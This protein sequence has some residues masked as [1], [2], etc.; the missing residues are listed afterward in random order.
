MARRFRTRLVKAT[1]AAARRGGY[2]IIGG[3]PRWPQLLLNP[4]LRPVGVQLVPENQ[5]GRS[6]LDAEATIAKARAEGLSIPQYVAR[7][8]DEHGVVEG[9]I[10]H[11][12]AVIPLPELKRIC[13]IG[14]GTGRFLEPIADIAKS[15]RYEVYETNAGWSEYLK[16]THEVVAHAADGAT[17][18]AT[19]D[20]SQDLVHAH[21]VFAYLPVRVCFAYFLEMCRVCACGGYVVFD[22]Y[23]DEDQDLSAMESWMAHVANY[24]IILPKRAILSLFARE[25][26]DLVDQGY[27]MKAFV[28]KTRYLMFR[29]R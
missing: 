28:G 7:L 19:P 2:A 3:G 9:F 6:Y 4:L 27:G 18:S 15:E 25:G 10:E 26:F 13:E 17:L 20:G 14:A 29:K 24:Q 12:R 8:W 22:G 16:R 23:M 5:I 1:R 21:Y 11:L